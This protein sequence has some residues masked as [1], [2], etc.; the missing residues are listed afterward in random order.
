MEIVFIIIIL[1]F[2]V[3]IHE[4][5]H[6][7]MALYLGDPT[8]RLAGRLTLNPIKHLDPV[9]S[10]LV[11]IIAYMTAGFA[12][13]WAKPVPYNPYNLKN[14]RSGEALVAFAGPLSNI[15]LATVFAI[16]IRLV[17]AMPEVF[18]SLANQEFIQM[19]SYIVLINIVLA[20]FN[21]IP[22]PPLDGSKLLFSIF[23][24]QYGRL[25]MTLEQ[26]GPILFIVVI[27][28]LWG[29]ISRVVPI[30]FKLLIGV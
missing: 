25:R 26:F 14:K 17:L 9:G 21:L 15:I 11:P 5:A 16:I 30:L 12:F 1:L 20:I 4:L 6:G 7:Y 22:V 28:F 19:I 8:A 29:F 2:S 24:D 3:I 13:G 23:P 10:V 27:F 18:G